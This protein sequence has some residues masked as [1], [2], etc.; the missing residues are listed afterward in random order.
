M[1]RVTLHIADEVR[2]GK[3]GALDDEAALHEYLRHQAVGLVQVAG[4]SIIDAGGRVRASSSRYPLPAEPANVA[5]VP[6]FQQLKSRHDNGML[7]AHAM[8]GVTRPDTWVFPMGRR[9]ETRDGRFAGAIAAGGR[10]DYFQ[11][12]YRDVRL[13]RDTKI[14]LVHRDGALVARNPPADPAL[15]GRRFETLDGILAARRRADPAASAGAASS[16]SG[17]ALAATQARSIAVRY[18]SPIDGVERF[19]AVHLV[20]GYPLAVVVSRDASLA[21]APWRAEAVGTALRTMA[22]GVLATALLVLVRRQFGRLDRARERFALAAAGSDEGVWD[23]QLAGDRIY[24]SARAREIFGLAPGPEA[25][26]RDQWFAAVR[27]HPDD[28]AGRREAIDAHLEGRAPVY[29]GE[30]RVRGLDGQYRW[31][32]VR[33]LCVR[34]AKGQPLRMAGSVTDIDAR[35]RAEDALRVSEQRLALAM[36]GSTGGHWVWDTR[37]DA[38]FVS[39]TVNQLFGVPF[40]L[41]PSTRREYFDRIP[42]HPAD[43]DAL[44]QIEH[45][46]LSGGAARFDIEYRIAL[47]D[48]ALRWILTRA[49]VFRDEA[50]QPQRVAGVSVDI[51]ARKRAEESQRQSEQR[52]AL[53]VA[54]SDDGVWDWDFTTN[55]AFE[56]A[57][58]RQLQ[59]LPPGP[60]LQPLAEL[61]ASLHVH[62]EDA[63]RRAEGMR[64]HLAGETPAYECEYRV[65]HDGGLE[66]SGPRYRWIRVRALCIRD[67]EGRPVRM[68]GSVS[69][70]DARKRGEQALRESQERYAL[71]LAGSNDGILDWDIAGD[72]MFASARA[73]R[74]IGLPPDERLLTRAQWIAMVMP[75]FHP[76]DVARVKAELHDNRNHPAEAH[77]GEYR[78]LGADGEY[79]WMRLRGRLVRDPAGNPIRWA[80]S[81]SDVDAL[82]KTEQALRRSEERY[83]LAV[84]GSNAGMWDWDITNDTLFVSARAQQLLGLAAGEPLRPRSEWAF[85]FEY[86][87][88]DVAA[89][90]SID[91]YLAGRSGHWEV[92]ARLRH[93]SGQWRWYRDRGVALRDGQGKAYRMAGSIEDVTDR[94]NAES[95]R[96]HLEVQLRQAQKLEAIGTLAGGIAHDFNNIL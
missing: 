58:A 63:P 56:S 88:D 26:S 39:G 52:F 25:Q 12:F 67:A 86:H 37:T 83:E 38:L 46:V 45:D 3:L 24:A 5:E 15:M 73:W 20:A 50:G 42:V 10:V 47:P 9:L 33:G 93:A 82:K 70:I 64:A 81:I 60:E 4:L 74:L 49:Q 59:A 53:A 2:A 76:G 94:K 14:A 6:A 77:E 87:P 17:A 16:G 21:L 7:V 54:G 48:G 22:L 19:G 1:D 71:A 31:V 11:N 91:D 34:D 62:P 92:E 96:E 13:E 28:V 61:N 43:K 90:R 41:Q 23:W 79:H 51:T 30:Y 35:R 29:A 75:R 72:R 80:G 78:L 84:D 44:R 32:R 36:T 40:D 57:R 69:D 27:L 85:A 95:A 68:A 8:R 55:M 66:K 89:E 18:R 65:R